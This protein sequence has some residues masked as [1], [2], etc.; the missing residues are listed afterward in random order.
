MN[1]NNINEYLEYKDGGVYWKKTKGSRGIKGNRFG[2]FD[3]RYRHGMFEGK[4]LREHQLVWFLHHG[5]FPLMLDHIDGNS[6]NNHIDNLRE[7][8]ASQNGM[9]AK[10]RKDNKTGCKGVFF[11]KNKGKYRVELVVNKQ[12]KNFGYFED[13]ELACL[14]AEEAR[15][16]YHGN[17]ARSI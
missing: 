10:M 11:I 2:S 6:L 14:V 15:D 7:V 8:S 1:L 3:G 16:K 17:F 5:V 12:K 9:N 4:M 13:E